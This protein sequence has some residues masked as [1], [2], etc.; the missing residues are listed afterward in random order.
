MWVSSCHRSWSLTKALTRPCLSAKARRDLKKGGLRQSKRG[1][2]TPWFQHRAWWEHQWPGREWTQTSSLRQNASHRDRGESSSSDS[3]TSRQQSKN[4]RYKYT[5][6]KYKYGQIQKPR[7]QTQESKLLLIDRAWSGPTHDPLLSGS[8]P[9]HCET[10]RHCNI[11]NLKATFP[12]E[13]LTLWRGYLWN[14]I[15]AMGRK[16]SAGARVAALWI[17]QTDPKPISNCAMHPF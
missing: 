9:S 8:Q 7:H 14:L 6:L 10:L 11:I 17:E 3:Q 15:I 4:A 16:T 2:H 1:E 5:R 12:S 13:T